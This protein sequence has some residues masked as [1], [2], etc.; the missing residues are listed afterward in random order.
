M[1]PYYLVLLF[2]LIIFLLIVIAYIPNKKQR[3][4]FYPSGNETQYYRTLDSFLDE[5]VKREFN[6]ECLDDE[7]RQCVLTNGS[8]GKC[9]LSGIC[10]STFLYDWS[11]EANS[12]YKCLQPIEGTGCTRYCNCLSLKGVHAPDCMVGCLSWYPPT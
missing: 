11:D 2:I 1:K 12:D 8:P 10:A 5:R 7:R 3:S 9:V 6:E 4:N